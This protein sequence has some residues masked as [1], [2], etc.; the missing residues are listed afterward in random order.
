MVAA[1]NQTTAATDIN[2]FMESDYLIPL[3]SALGGVVLILSIVLIVICCRRN[4]RAQRLINADDINVKV[5]KATPAVTTQEVDVEMGN[6]NGVSNK[7]ATN[8]ENTSSM[9][10]RNEQ[11]QKSVTHAPVPGLKSIP[12]L[13]LRS[14]SVDSDVMIGSDDYLNDPTP[15]V[16]IVPPPPAVKCPSPPQPDT[17][18]QESLDTIDKSSAGLTTPKLPK[19]RG[20][21][22]TGAAA[23]S[24]L[25]DD[26]ETT[27]QRAT[28]LFRSDTKAYEFYTKSIV[29]YE[30]SRNLIQ[31][32][33]LIGKGH[34]GCV[35]SGM[36]G[37][38]PNCKQRKQK[39]AVKTMKNSA[40]DSEKQEFLYELEIM[41]LVNSL[42]HPNIIK[43][44][45]CVTKT[46]PYLIVLELMTN[47][48]LQKFLRDTKTKDVYY[49][50][51]GKSNSFNE[52]HLLKFALDIAKGMEALADLQL[53]HRDLACRNILID[54]NLTC[55]VADFGFAKDVLNKPE[56]KSKSV[57]QRPRPTRWLAPESLFTFKHS[58][59]SDVWSYGIVLWE[60]VTLGN[61][62]YPHM[63]SREVSVYV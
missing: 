38:L 43:L 32:S 33:K 55:K 4:I 19:I 45:G 3:V 17:S 49:N 9:L 11:P 28:N 41:R 39:V 23:P 34:F 48:N 15:A 56:Y 7:P 31:T 53:L 60:I 54:S 29:N 42:N 12:A 44:L 1:H 59:Q 50:L 27:I 10:R 51:H 24:L 63:G 62:P 61:L 6:N 37:K 46:Q 8:D 5:V 20:R 57:F 13:Q 22:K 35:Y 14:P 2:V 18:S 52:Q 30:M 16:R 40:P 26:K 25:V 47:G 36:A 21:S 58:I